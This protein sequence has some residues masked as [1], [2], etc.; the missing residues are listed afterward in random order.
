MTPDAR[1]RLAIA[2]GAV[3][4]FFG[5]VA[6]TGWTSSGELDDQ[7][8]QELSTFCYALSLAGDYENMIMTAAFSG[9]GDVF[10][11]G[12]AIDT[13]ISSFIESTLV[14]YAPS[15]YREQAGDLV[16]GLQRALRGELSPDEADEYVREFRNLEGQA[17]GD[18][19]QFDGEVVDFGGEAPFGFGD[20]GPGED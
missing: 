17:R 20:E 11:G 7:E 8:R 18:C 4:A 10:G 2:A 6:L 19:E 16:E 15:Q 14:D 13:G 12:G 1:R 3:A 9:G 5:F